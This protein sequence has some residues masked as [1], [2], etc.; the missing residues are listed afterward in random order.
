[1]S[2]EAP[3]KTISNGLVLHLDAGNNKSYPGSGTSWRDLSGNGN[4]GTLVANNTAPTFNSARGG[5]IDFVYGYC[6]STISLP[7]SAMTL[8]IVFKVNNVQNWTDIAV[9]DD[10]TNAIMLERG[11]TSAT[12]Y[13]NGYLRY[14]S[15]YANGVGSATDSLA[16]PSQYIANSNILHTVLTVGDS[17]A[18]SFCNGIRQGSAAVTENKTFNRLVLANDLLRANRMCFCNIYLVKLYNRALTP[19]EVLQNYDSTKSRFGL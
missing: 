11:S 15:S 1:M 7:S 9:L 19:A 17:V 8:E 18:T 10:G 12:P 14:Y 13:T 5:S 4:N 16:S 2:I 6:T 3:I